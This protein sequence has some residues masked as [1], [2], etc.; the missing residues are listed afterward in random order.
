[1]CP[2]AAPSHPFLLH[3]TAFYTIRSWRSSN[4]A[5][6]Q[7]GGRESSLSSSWLSSQVHSF[8]HKAVV[9]VCKCTQQTTPAFFQ[10]THNLGKEGIWA[11]IVPSLSCQHTGLDITPCTESL[12]S[13]IRTSLSVPFGV[14]QLQIAFEWDD[15][16]P[17]YCATE[18]VLSDA[19]YLATSAPDNHTVHA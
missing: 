13:R 10:F 7:P 15:Y 18:L 12:R 11:C 6:L 2:Q 16:I 5:T 17:H 1:M 3:V 9:S 8:T 19:A 14:E 4:C